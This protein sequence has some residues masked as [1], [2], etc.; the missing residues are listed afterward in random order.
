M[1]EIAPGW[2]VDVERGPD[3][4]FIRVHCPH[5]M[6]GDE[7]PLAECLWA[8]ISQHFTYR[9][10][11]ELD[12]VDCLH[13]YLVGQLVLLHKRLATHDGVLRLS[14]LS[15]GN[16]NV[17]RACRLEDRFPQ[18]HTRSDALHGHKPVKPR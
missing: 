1:L 15:D 8:A 16:Q 13:S 10:V 17:L 6:T 4:L 7:P 18:Y 9:V 5:P 3:W 2:Q 14:G 11:L 12:E